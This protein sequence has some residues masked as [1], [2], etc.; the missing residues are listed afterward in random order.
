MQTLTPLAQPLTTV[1]LDSLVYRLRERSGRGF[2]LTRTDART[3]IREAAAKVEAPTWLQVEGTRAV[4][5]YDRAAMA[6]ILRVAL[7]A[8]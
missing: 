5:T 2:T 6:A 3:A 8:L 7:E 1:T 4:R